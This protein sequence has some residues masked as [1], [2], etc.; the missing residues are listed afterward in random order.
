MS[1]GLLVS[2]QNRAVLVQQTAEQQ[3]AMAPTNA[4]LTQA[5]ADR[6]ATQVVLDATSTQV[7]VQ[8]AVTSVAL[9]TSAVGSDLQTTASGLQYRVITEGSGPKP[10]VNDTVTIDYRGILQADASEFDSSYSRNQ[11]STFP[12]NQVIP[13]FTEGLQLMSVG[14]KYVFTIPP[15]LAYGE[16]GRAPVIP[17][18]ATLIFEIELLDIVAQ[19]TVAAPPTDIPAATAEA[20]ESPAATAEATASS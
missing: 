14:S 13:G 16:T 8:A 3:T 6:Q 10:T 18:N 11:P 15:D 2:S 4:V 5:A 1:A 12:L 17:P 9:A 20:T 19:P 7:A